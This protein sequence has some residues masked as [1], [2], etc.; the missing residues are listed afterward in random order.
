[1]RLIFV[2]ILILFVL[3]FVRGAFSF[4]GD[5]FS[6][7]AL[8]VGTIVLLILYTSGKRAKAQ[9]AKR[10]EDFEYG[11]KIKKTSRSD[12]IRGYSIIDEFGWVNVVD[13]ESSHEVE[14]SLKVTAAK[15]GANAVIKMH[16][17]LRTESYV[18]GHGKK[19]NPYYRNRTVYDGEGVAVSIS[20]DTRNKL[21]KVQENSQREAN[22]NG[23]KA[24]KSGYASGW[25]AI[26]GN[27]VF[28]EIFNQTDNAE[29]SFQILR[30]YLLKLK[31]SPYKY[32]VFWDGK[33]IKFAHALK[34]EPIN[35]QLG[36]ILT[37]NLTISNAELTISDVDQRVDD[38]IVTWAHIK[39]SA[40][41]SN[42]NYSKDYED[43][44]IIQKTRQLKELDLVL[45]FQVIA[46]EI[47]V[48]EL[49]AI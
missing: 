46:G 27:N 25:V 19:G 22:K 29:L 2:A 35:A 45:R 40:I 15:K 11:Q 21:K 18:A 8:I 41:I 47:V 10:K 33:F 23:L 28:G 37:K 38:L 44:L 43:K 48:P 1:M 3:D 4:V 17:R 49:T 6:V 34:I 30:K 26:D 32:H 5:N 12:H 13:C 14:E 7:I 20:H 9:E 31:N 16:W 39:T 24:N 36:D 42:D